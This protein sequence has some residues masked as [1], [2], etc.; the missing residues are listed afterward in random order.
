MLE[1]VDTVGV[2]GE[3]EVVDRSVATAEA[4]LEAAAE[5]GARSQTSTAASM[6]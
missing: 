5:D 1:E 6:P 3:D 4:V 2:A